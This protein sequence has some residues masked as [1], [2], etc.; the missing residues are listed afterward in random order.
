MI[1]GDGPDEE[2]V[3]TFVV[4]LWLINDGWIAMFALGVV[5]LPGCDEFRRK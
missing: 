3:K 5:A 4:L 2:G 1:L